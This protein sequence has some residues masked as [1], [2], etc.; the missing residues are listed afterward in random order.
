[1][2]Q[3]AVK[4]MM[5][6]ACQARVEKAVK[7]VPGVT[8]VNVSLLTN[9]MAVEGT[10]ASSDVVKAVKNAGYGAKLMKEA[11]V[12][13]GKEDHMELF[14]ELRRNFL[15]SLFVLLPLMTISMGSMFF[16]A[17][18]FQYFA[19]RPALAGLIEMIL[20]AVILVIN[21]RFFVNGFRGADHNFSS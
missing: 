1:M 11:E 20:C 6:A 17:P 16:S 7:A 3:Y 9:S 8:D 4:G 21:R 18:F 2:E 12:S 13:D 10:A 19:D 5:C 15:V 14:R